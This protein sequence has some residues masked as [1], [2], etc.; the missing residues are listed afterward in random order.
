[1]VHGFITE[2]GIIYPPYKGSF[3]N[4]QLNNKIY[5]KQEELNL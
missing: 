1:M 5:L 2:Q 3:E 4:L